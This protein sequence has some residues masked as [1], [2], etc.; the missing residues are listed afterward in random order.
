MIDCTSGGVSSRV[1]TM[2]RSLRYGYQVPFAEQVRHGADIATMAVGLII[3]GD[4]AEAILQNGQADLIGVGREI[5]HNPNWPL[6]AAQKLGL[7][8]AFEQVPQQTGFW[9]ASRARRGFGC[10]P[11]TWQAGLDDARSDP[12]APT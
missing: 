1:P 12:H 9:L 10:A 2:Y 3:H 8:S 7:A 5:M 4:Q 6:D 11:S